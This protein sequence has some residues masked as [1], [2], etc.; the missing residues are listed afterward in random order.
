M[1]QVAVINKDECIDCAACESAC[2]SGAIT[3]GD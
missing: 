2:P 3:M 1:D